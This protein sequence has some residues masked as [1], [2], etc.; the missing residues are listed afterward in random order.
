VPATPVRPRIEPLGRDHDRTGFSCGKGALD[1]YFQQQVTQD[2]RRHLAAP[3]VMFMPDGAIG[4]Y[5]TLSST[6]LRL[7]DLPGDVARRLPRYPLI[8]ATLI[9]RLA[10]DRRYHGQGWGSFLLIDALRR[11]VTSEIASFAVVVDAIDDEARDFYTHASFLSLPD[12]PRR[13]FRR[14]SDIA[15]LFE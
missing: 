15:A 2:A 11:C 14:M 6:A 4:G 8:P 10:L 5:Y 3:F 13:L 1:R 7:Q 9:G 12:S